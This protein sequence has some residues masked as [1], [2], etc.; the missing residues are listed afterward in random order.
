MP[1][2]YFSSASSIKDIS[3]PNF[4]QQSSNPF[5][6]NYKNARKDAYSAEFYKIRPEIISRFSDR[7]FLCGELGYEIHHIDYNKDNND[8]NNLMLLCKSCH[9]KTN[10]SRAYW[11]KY[12]KNKMEIV[13][14]FH[15]DK[16][17]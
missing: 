2:N 16:E 12:L 17:D 7:C 10:S 4:S 1:Y 8:K 6:P 11:E 9:A 14:H 15:Y 13:F 5:A 3:I